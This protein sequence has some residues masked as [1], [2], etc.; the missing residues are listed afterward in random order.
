M[1]CPKC[2][3]STFVKD[4]RDYVYQNIETTRRRRRCRKCGHRYSTVEIV[5]VPMVKDV[6][7]PKHAPIRKKGNLPRRNL[8]Q[9]RLMP[10]YHMRQ[11]GSFQIPHDTLEAATDRVDQDFDDMTDEELEE[12]VLGGK[13]TIDDD[14]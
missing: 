13:I 3:G 4:S 7:L 9:K 8:I 10:E 12:L 2:K 14:L 11:D 5:W 6:G 1:K